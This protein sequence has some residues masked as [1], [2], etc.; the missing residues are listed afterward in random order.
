[1]CLSMNDGSVVWQTLANS[2][3]QSGG[4]FSSPIIATVAG[5]RQLLVQ[6]RLELCG[7]ELETGEVLWRQPIEAFRGM[8]ILTPL[9]IG[10]RI[11][12]SAYSGKAQMYQIS[13]AGGQWSANLVWEQ[14][15]QAYMSSPVVIGNRIYLH[16]RNER[17]TALD[18][19]TGRIALHYPPD[20]KVRQYDL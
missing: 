13:N 14:E 12:T 16:L 10:D 3:M 4:A 19:T 17:L 5:K 9:P 15:R 20:R 18:T 7:V 1:M 6:T 2:G 11:F 8:N